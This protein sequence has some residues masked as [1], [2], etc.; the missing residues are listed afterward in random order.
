MRYKRS[1]IDLHRKSVL[2]DIFEYYSWIVKVEIDSKNF[3]VTI[4]YCDRELYREIDDILDGREIKLLKR[5]KNYATEGS[6]VYLKGEENF[7][8]TKLSFEN[9]DLVVYDLDP[10]WKQ[11][12]AG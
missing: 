9:K 11:T 12:S 8:V 2:I 5:Y 3:I 1:N 4:R 6:F 10:K 7:D